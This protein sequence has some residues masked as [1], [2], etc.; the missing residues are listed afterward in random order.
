MTDVEKHAIVA[1]AFH[2]VVDGACDNIPGSEFGIGMEAGHKALAVGEAQ[3]RTLTAQGL[4]DQQRFGP[5]VKQA[6]GVKLVELHIGNPTTPSPR[7]RDAVAAGAV[8]I[9]GVQIG[10]TRT[11][12]RKGD[13]FGLK[14]TDFI[15]GPIQHVGAIAA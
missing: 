12:G 15:A 2:F 4:A 13:D 11:P 6:G 3:Q 7:Y 5:G 14:Q 1:E 9:A 10:F 8:G